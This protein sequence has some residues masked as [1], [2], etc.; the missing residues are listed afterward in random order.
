MRHDKDNAW[1]ILGGK[2]VPISLLRTL[3]LPNSIIYPHGAV[4]TDINNNGLPEIVVIRFSFPGG[5]ELPIPIYE[6]HPN[7][8]F[9]DISSSIFADGF[10]PVTDFGRGII[11]GDINGNGYDDII[12][13]DHGFDQ[14]PFPGAINPVYLNNGEGQLIDRSADFSKGAD[15]THSVA[16]GDL[17]GNGRADILFNNLGI[18][19]PY[20]VSI[21]AQGEPEIDALTI[22]LAM[23]SYAS[24]LITDL[25]N[26]GRDQIILGAD[27]NIGT[28]GSIILDWSGESFTIKELPNSQYFDKEIVL[29]IEATDLNNN[30]L[31]DLILLK[32]SADPFYT[33][34]ALQF[35][36]QQRNGDFIDKTDD[37]IDKNSFGTSDTG[38]SWGRYLLVEDLNGNGL[39]DIIVEMNFP[40]NHKIFFQTSPGNFHQADVEFG[41]LNETLVLADV[42]FDGRKELIVIGADNVNIYGFHVADT[43]FIQLGSI[44]F[45]EQRDNFQIER[46]GTH[47]VIVTDATGNTVEHSDIGRINF[48][49]GSLLFDIDSANLGFT[50]RIY[51]AAYGRTPDEDGLRFWVETIDSLTSSEPER[52]DF[53]AREF[54]T[55]PEFLSLYG[56]DPSDLDYVDAMYQNVLGRLPDQG[57]YDFW[58]GAMEEGLDR[59]D[60]L[61]RFAESPEN[62]ERTAPDLNDGIWVV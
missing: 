28:S 59:A 31:K 56:T 44:V 13:A 41:N 53:L 42:T 54:L 9:T 25:S 1:S 55:A 11:A 27:K 10:V 23:P 6:I 61:V 29:D 26:Q 39:K 16:W 35:L 24:A 43:V 60:I 15:F 57:G 20:I 22:P 51:A 46:I 36:I 32:T 62:Q 19:K 37:F 14:M 4:V 18:G 47:D 7:G 8:M 5:Q 12:I 48:E 40:D 33:G 2:N 50:Y 34:F 52:F 17:T 45:L 49:D 38:S 58:V 30:G 21:D 3:S